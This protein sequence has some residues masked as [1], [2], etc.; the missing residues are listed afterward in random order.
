MVLCFISQSSGEEYYI[1][2]DAAITPELKEKIDD[3]IA[4][5]IEAYSN[6]NDGD[7]YDF[8]IAD[9]VEEVMDDLG[10]SFTEYKPEMVIYY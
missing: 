4:E 9:A 6:T 3:E 10:I 8:R 5:V 2:T 7:F 1:K